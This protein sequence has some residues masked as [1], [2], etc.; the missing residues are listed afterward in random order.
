MYIGL[1]SFRLNKNTFHQQDAEDLQKDK[2]SEKMFKF[3]FDIS[4]ESNRG[5]Q[6][7]EVCCLRGRGYF[8][9]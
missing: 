6:D 3:A 7:K 9:R 1:S 5:R 2:R 8:Q 4:G